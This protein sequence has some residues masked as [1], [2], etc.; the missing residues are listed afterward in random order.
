MYVQSSKTSSL[1]NLALLFALHLL[2]NCYHHAWL[3]NNSC[4]IGIQMEQD[5]IAI[6]FEGAFHWKICPYLTGWQDKLEYRIVN[7]KYACTVHKQTVKQDIHINV[8]WVAR[9]NKIIAFLQHVSISIY[10]ID[11]S[12]IP[13]F[14]SKRNQ[15]DS[16]TWSCG[17]MASKPK[18]DTNPL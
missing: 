16:G 15:K 9:Y 17:T 1:Q 14:E 2:C 5:Q 4:I 7:E 12:T 18:V 6:N 10:I 11:W 8:R 3:H 13:K